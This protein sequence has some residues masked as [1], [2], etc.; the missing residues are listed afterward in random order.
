MIGASHTKDIAPPPAIM[1]Q[2]I[3]QGAAVQRA[4]GCD[5]R[6]PVMLR[7]TGGGKGADRGIQIGGGGTLGDNQNIVVLTPGRDRV[8]VTGVH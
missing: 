5:F 8:R 1:G 2:V 7:S 3:Q 6:V 4:A